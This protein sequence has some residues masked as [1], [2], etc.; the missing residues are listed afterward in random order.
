VTDQRNDKMHDAIE[1]AADQLMRVRRCSKRD[2]LS[3]VTVSYRE[4]LRDSFGTA[5]ES[6]W[7]AMLAIAQELAGAT[8]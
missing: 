7:R 2:A 6:Y 5:D 8:V 4:N 3:A 1:G